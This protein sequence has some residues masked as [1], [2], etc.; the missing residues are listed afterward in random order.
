MTAPAPRRPARRPGI[1]PPAPRPAAGRTRAVNRGLLVLTLRLLVLAAA[2][3]AW[4]LATDAANSPY[5]LPPSAIVPAM[6]HQW[7]SGPASHLWLTPDATANLL[8]SI[9]RMLVGW[10]VA[11]FAGIVLGVAIGRVPLLAD[12]TEPVVH[13]ARAV[14]PPALVPVFL[15]VF[16]IGT[17]MELATIIFGVIWPVLINSIDGARHVHPGHL[18]TA[19]AFRIPP[20]TRL[21]RIIL[22]SAAPEI[23]AGLRLSLALALVMMIVSEF[24]GSTNGIGREMLQDTSLFNVSGMWG[25]IVLLGLLGMLLNTAFSLLEHRVLAWQRTAGPA[26]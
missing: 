10:A 2:V 24:V 1:R 4:Q 23:L 6:Y 18:E 9:A 21:F 13:F 25:V 20:A 22:P 11:S 12:L 7:F 15:F 19:R 26:A 14:P 17:P 5:F 16:N 8:P 3:A